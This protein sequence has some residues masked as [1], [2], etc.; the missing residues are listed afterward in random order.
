[1]ISTVNVSV[2]TCTASPTIIQQFDERTPV[3]LIRNLSASKMDRPDSHTKDRHSN[4]KPRPDGPFHER[5][6]SPAYQPIN[7]PLLTDNRY[8]NYDT[9]SQIRSPAIQ[10]RS[11]NTTDHNPTIPAYGTNESVCTNKPGYTPKLPT[12]SPESPS[13]CPNQQNSRSSS[14]SHQ[15][16]HPPSESLFVRAYH[17]WRREISLQSDPFN[18]ASKLERN[19]QLP[20]RNMKSGGEYR[21]EGDFDSV[22]A[23]LA[24]S[25]SV[26]LS[27]DFWARR[28]AHK[29]KGEEFTEKNHN[30][31]G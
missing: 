13:F 20:H 22:R 10:A 29:D 23:R 25:T 18:Q 21:S 26:K 5:F 11:P 15:S 12:Y 9:M 24:L 30:R 1:M 6:A 8:S 2:Q 7:P 31:E 27:H 19:D 14:P 4:S 28:R 16:S 17:H 3:L